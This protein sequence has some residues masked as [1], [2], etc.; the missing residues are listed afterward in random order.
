MTRDQ[1]AELATNMDHSLST[2]DRNYNIGLN[3]QVS[4]R[5]ARLIAN[6]YHNAEQVHDEDSEDDENGSD[7]EVAEQAESLKQKVI[8]KTFFGKKA[9][10]S[11][12]D[13]DALRQACAGIVETLT[14]DPSKKIIASKVMTA[15]KD[16][17]AKYR[18]LQNTYT[19]KQIVD[20]LCMEVRV[21]R[22]RIAKCKKT[23]DK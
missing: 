19:E 9:V 2:A 5:C 4:T 1:E 7:Q 21:R 17:G 18:Y 22:G 15:L 16:A 3:L 6:M 12:D 23:D 11:Q 20:K 13:R 10:F 8:N 14:E